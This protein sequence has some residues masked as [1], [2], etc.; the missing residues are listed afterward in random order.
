MVFPTYHLYEELIR[1]RNTMIMVLGML[2]LLGFTAWGLI[3]QHKP[4]WSTRAI[5]IIGVG[6][7]Y[8]TLVAVAVYDLIGPAAR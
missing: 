8:A 6:G 7:F 5:W 2:V 3:R 4:A 1:T